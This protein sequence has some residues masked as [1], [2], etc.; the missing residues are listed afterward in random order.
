MGFET[1]LV[2]EGFTKDLVEFTSLLH[3]LSEKEQNIQWKN[4]IQNLQCEARKARA[5]VVMTREAAAAAARYSRIAAVTDKKKVQGLADHDSLNKE[6]KSSGTTG[7]RRGGRIIEDQKHVAND[8]FVMVIVDGME[9]PESTNIDVHE[10]DK[11][12]EDDEDFV[13]LDW[14]I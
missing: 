12:V 5:M 6:E 13:R 9:E 2:E 11:S 8:G 1:E 14:E 10:N 4:R 3:G 7:I